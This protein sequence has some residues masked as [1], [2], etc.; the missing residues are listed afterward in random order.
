MLD[1]EP[2]V[3]EEFIALTRPREV[4]TIAVVESHDIVQSASGARWQLEPLAWTAT[5]GGP[6]PQEP[7]PIPPWVGSPL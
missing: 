2:K 4:L 7:F 1:R 6:E 5:D 3:G